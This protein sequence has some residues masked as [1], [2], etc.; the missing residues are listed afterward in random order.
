M[1]FINER[2]PIFF[3]QVAPPTTWDNVCGGRPHASQVSRKAWPFREIAA[4]KSCLVVVSCGFSMFV[5]SQ[6]LVGF[7]GLRFRLWLLFN[8][9][10][11]CPCIEVNLRYL[12]IYINKYIEIILGFRPAGSSTPVEEAPPPG[13]LW[14]T[15]LNT[16][17]DSDMGRLH[18]DYL[19]ML[20]QGANV[21]RCYMVLKARARDKCAEDE[22]SDVGKH[23][24]IKWWCSCVLLLIILMCV[25]PHA[26]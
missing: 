17:R 5:F 10:P 19:D 2:K 22:W 8:S 3:C 7:A 25:W 20:T 16:S 18:W 9:L 14:G 11:Q 6:S 21:Y 4:C 23:V 1:Q 12:Y 26:L 15:C 24:Q 13:P